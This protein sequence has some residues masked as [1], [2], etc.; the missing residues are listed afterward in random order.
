MGF[1]PHYSLGRFDANSGKT[2]FALRVSE[3]RWPVSTDRRAATGYVRGARDLSDA[4][5]ADHHLDDGIPLMPRLNPQL[6][7]VV[8]HRHR[9]VVDGQR[10]ADGPGL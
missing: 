1:P 9:S 8:G 10:R 6:Q 5:A 3:S 7:P 4:V 2:R